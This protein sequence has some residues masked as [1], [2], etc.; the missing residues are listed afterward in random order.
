MLEKSK[1]NLSMG[2]PFSSYELFSYLIQLFIL[3]MAYKIS[4]LFLI[5]SFA[6]GRSGFIGSLGPPGGREMGR[7]KNRTPSS[8]REGEGAREMGCC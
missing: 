4:L 1:I 7:A 6:Q 8:I 5:I 3:L 2:S